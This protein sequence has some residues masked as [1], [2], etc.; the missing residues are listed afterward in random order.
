MKRQQEEMRRQ[1]DE[2]RRRQS[3]EKTK[4]EEINEEESKKE[5]TNSEDAKP[6]QEDLKKQSEAR[7][8]RTIPPPIVRRK[9]RRTSVTPSDPAVTEPVH[10]PQSPK[11]TTPA[12]PPPPFP[13]H[14]APPVPPVPSISIRP[15]I[16]PPI[17]ARRL[18]FTP[19]Q[20][21]TNTNTTIKKKV[22]YSEPISVQH[23]PQSIPEPVIKRS[24]QR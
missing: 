2:E 6:K 7:N 19:A 9:L 3:Q 18:S 5:R 4:R 24:N 12:P 11:G 8:P 21:N 15:P 20:P 10:R 13:S 14:P 1:Q 17:P 16:P 23:L 22:R